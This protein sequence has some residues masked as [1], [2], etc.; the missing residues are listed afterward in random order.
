MKRKT[1][2]LF[3]LLLAFFLTLGTFQIQAQNTGQEYVIQQND[4]LSKISKKVYGNPHLYN[5]IIEATNEKASLDKSFQQI[6]SVKN[7]IV[8]QKLW[9]P[10][11]TDSAQTKEKEEA[12]L[13]AVPKTNCEIRI[14]YNYQV[15]AIGKINAKWESDGLDLE[16]RARR[17]YELRHNARVNARYMMQNKAEVKELQARDLVKYGN[18]NGPTFE[19]LLKKNTDK[20]LSEAEG[21]QSIIDSSSRTSAVYNSDCL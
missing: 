7:L 1:T 9:I 5:L 6:G 17:A 18:P 3:N 14:W 15:V 10:E 12:V 2:Y 8:G 19:Y 21:F 11:T 13:V 4:W 20:G 16:T